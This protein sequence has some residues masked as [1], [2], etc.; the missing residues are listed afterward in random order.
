MFLRILANKLLEMLVEEKHVHV[1]PVPRTGKINK[2]NIIV[3][4]K[5][6][7]FCYK[8]VYYTLYL[9]KANCQ[10]SFLKGA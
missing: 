7:K 10:K 6:K 3:F 2:N 8:M 1:C 9:S 4:L 5:E